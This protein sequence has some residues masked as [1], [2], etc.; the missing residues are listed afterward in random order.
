MKT[1]TFALLMLVGLAIS[2]GDKK[3]PEAAAEPAEPA[4][5]VEVE[6]EPEP[7]PEPPPPPPP[8]ASNADF[9]VTVT[10]ADGSSQSGHVKRVERSSD[11]FAETGWED[12]DYKTK[13]ELEGNGT[14]IEAPWSDIK[15]ITV[16]PGSVPGDV[17]CTYSSE[18]S[19]WMYTCEL[20][21]PSTA[22]TTDGKKWTVTTRHK[23]RFTLDDGT[24]IE[25][26]LNKH[27]ARAQDERVVTIDDP[28]GENYDMYK[29]LQQQLRDEK[30]T[31]PKSITIK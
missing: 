13:I 3:P 27:P 23:W 25:F 10:L 4:P 21:T 2:C 11:W 30:G 28:I 14:L 6:P 7:E 9:N 5:V 24:E 22:V 12:G 15:S 20:R 18:Y 16:R 1:R 17:D 19:P 8:P 31:L 26:W 29:T